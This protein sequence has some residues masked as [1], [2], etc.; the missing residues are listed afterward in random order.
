M[1]KLLALSLALLL[2]TACGSGTPVPELAP[3]TA[4]PAMTSPTTTAPTTTAT[5]AT[6]PTTTM[7]ATEAPP[8]P[9][10]PDAAQ[11]Y[12]DIRYIAWRPDRV[13]K[14]V[15][16]AGEFNPE[17]IHTF[18]FNDSVILQGSEAL[19]AEVLE[20]GKNPGLGVRSLHAQ[21]I[22]GAGIRVAVLDQ[23]FLPDHP[24]YEGRIIK[25]FDSGVGETATPS[26]MHAPSVIGVLAGETTGTAP[27]ALV[28]FAAVPVWLEDSAYYANSLYWV[29]EENAKLPTHDKIR[30]V[31]VSA[32]P[33]GEYSPFT[34]NQD[35]WDEAILAAQ[36]AGLL[37]LDCSNSN[38]Q[39]GFIDAGYYDRDDPESPAKGTAG[40]PGRSA[41]VLERYLYAPASLR[42]FAEQYTEGEYGYQYWSR[43]GN[44]WAVPYVAGVLAMGFQVNP[45]LGNDAATALLF[46][47]AATGT[48]GGNIVDPVAFIAAVQAT[49]E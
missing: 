2:T 16:E 45:D 21:G 28:Y 44:S 18:T 8:E 29:I 22:T 6:V 3:I 49:L 34:R 37:V 10:L 17:F 39:T 47:T 24:E 27:G 5:P 48:N 32:A 14:P 42:T 7:P 4:S 38:A 12:A 43:G 46:E 36:E 35:M 15:Y 20:A 41:T 25:V 11:R 31:S 19:Q 26:S 30:I 13:K 40:F 9:T 23:H 33:S 1:K